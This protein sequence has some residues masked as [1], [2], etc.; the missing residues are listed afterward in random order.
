MDWITEEREGFAI[1]S[2]RGDID[3]TTAPDLQR[4]F[5]RLL[6]KATR[7]FVVDL[8]EVGFIDSAGLAA[9]IHLYK[10]VRIGEGDVRLAAIPVQV[11]PVFKITRL[12]QVFDI[13]ATSAA[14]AESF[15]GH[16]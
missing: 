2:P 11:L 12:D 7:Y 15:A 13:F 1:I 8:S 4:E 5:D 10:R 9:L 14:A 3:A 16:A 6:A